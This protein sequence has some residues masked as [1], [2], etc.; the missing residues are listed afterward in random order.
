MA[1]FAPIKAGWFKW[2]V[3]PTTLYLVIWIV[4]TFPAIKSVSIH[5]FADDGDGL[6]NV[7][8]IWWV[9][10]SLVEWHRLP[11]ITPLLHAPAGTTLIGQTLNPF[12]GLAGL[13]LHPWLTL[14]QTHNALVIFSFVS[15]GLT[16]FWLAHEFSGSYVGSLI[17][18]F[19]FTFSNFHFNHAMSHLQLVSLEWIPL[20][21][22]VWWRL[23]TRPTVTGALGAAL[24]LFLVE[25]TD[26]YYF[27][28]PL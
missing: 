18:G 17:G 5:F 15:A 23:L 4:Y 28:T 7:W 11:Y 20:F 10:R 24:T 26:H 19:I 16:A 13:V 6:Q 2:L 8:N 1:F 27:F 21:L 9:H 3:G 12:N 25:L 14:V 22:L